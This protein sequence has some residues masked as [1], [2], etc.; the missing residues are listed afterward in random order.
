MSTDTE[1]CRKF[2]KCETVNLIIK[3]SVM[4]EHITIINNY[5]FFCYVNQLGNTE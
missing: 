4:S 5:I 3:F 2:M 1:I